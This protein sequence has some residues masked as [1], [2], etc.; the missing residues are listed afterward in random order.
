[1][2]TGSGA[3]VPRQLD[4]IDRV[5]DRKRAREVGKE[6]EARLQR[7]DEKGLAPGIVVGDLQPELG[8][9]AGDFVRRQVNLADAGVGLYEARSR[10]YRFARRSMSRL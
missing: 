5:Q 1:V 2:A 9:A 4:E 7:R 8:D 3:V 6:D 10:W